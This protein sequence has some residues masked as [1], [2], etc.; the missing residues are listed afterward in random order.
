[1]CYGAEMGREINQRELR[2]DSGAIMRKLGEGE[3]FIVTRNGVPVAEL[4]PLRR[5][6][7]V[8]AEAAV[9]L[10]QAAPGVDYERFRAD[11]DTIASQDA[12]PRG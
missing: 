2:N 4:T 9:A 10:F 11:L 8:A 6:R 5:H 3:T 7:F 12:T 1:M